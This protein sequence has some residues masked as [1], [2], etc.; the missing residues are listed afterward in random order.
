M[1]K[2]IFTTFALALFVL[3]GAAGAQDAAA[4][5]DALAQALAD[6]ATQVKAELRSGEGA[7]PK[8]VP[9]QDKAEATFIGTVALVDA[10]DFL[11]DGTPFRL[12]AIDT[13]RPFDQFH[14]IFCLGG[15][16]N[17]SCGRLREGRRVQFTADVLTIEEG[18]QAGL[19]LFVAKRIK[20]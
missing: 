2:K 1:S 20:T 12:V 6:Y 15:S 17:N 5:K 18:D 3:A 19:A 9:R 11:D 8:A 16:F 13:N 4:S 14:F 10:T 7:V